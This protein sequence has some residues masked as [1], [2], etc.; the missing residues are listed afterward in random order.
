M[1]GASASQPHRMIA[2]LKLPRNNV[3]G[4]VT[5]ARHVVESMTKSPWF[6]APRPPL[7]TVQAAIDALA[8]AQM[9]TLSKT[10]GTVATRDAR[11]R[12]L[13]SV[14]DELTAYVQAVA[15]ANVE[16]AASIIESAGMSVKGLSGPKRRVFATRR[17]PTRDSVILVARKAGDRAL[18]EWAYRVDADGSAW[19]LWASTN[20]AKTTVTGLTPGARLLFRYRSSV[21]NV[22][23]DWSDPIAYVVG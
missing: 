7:A 18:Y 19:T 12:D 9:A 21:K 1:M 20:G 8:A 5:C 22:W 13:R 3:P 11:R 16:Y 6:P 14:L 23:S 2:V 17:G 10:V 4:I 15:D